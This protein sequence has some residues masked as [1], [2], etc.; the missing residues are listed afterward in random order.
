MPV[1]RSA[2]ANERLLEDILEA[3]IGLLGL[4]NQLL[5]VGRQVVTE[6]AGRV[7]L[8]CLDQDGVVYVAEVKKQRTP[9]EVVA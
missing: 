8:L 4:P 1:G 2:L 7:D 6:Y 3:D 5:V 9:R